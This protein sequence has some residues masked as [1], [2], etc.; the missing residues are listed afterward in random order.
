[1]PLRKV[2]KYCFDS[3]TAQET[4]EEK[5]LDDG[6]VRYAVD[7]S[8]LKFELTEKGMN[9]FREHEYT[10]GVERASDFRKYF[11]IFCFVMAM[12]FCFML[13]KV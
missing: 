7:D 10:V 2:N 11:A 8:G 12:I 4:V 9:F 5:L 1:M 13:K 6:L 3:E